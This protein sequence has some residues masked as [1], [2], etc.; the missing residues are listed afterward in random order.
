VRTTEDGVDPIQAHPYTRSSAFR[1]G[2]TGGNEQGF[3]IG[4]SGV[5]PHRISENS[6]EGS[7]VSAG[8]SVLYHKMVSQAANEKATRGAD[9]KIPYIAE[10]VL[11]LPKSY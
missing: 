5:R 6:F 4:P 3:D 7:P 11:R 1:Y 2:G 9:E 8:H 10:R